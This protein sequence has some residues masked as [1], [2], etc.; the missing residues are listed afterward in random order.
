[1]DRSVPRVSARAYRRR[2]LSTP[3]HRS[4]RAVE[5]VPPR[6]P[7]RRCEE[8]PLQKGGAKE[9]LCSQIAM[10]NTPRTSHRTPAERSRFPSARPCCCFPRQLF[11]FF[12]F[13]SGLRAKNTLRFALL[14]VDHLRAGLR[15]QGGGPATQHGAVADLNRR[16]QPRLQPHH[17]RRHG[18]G[19]AR[20]EEAFGHETA[21]H[22]LRKPRRRR[23]EGRRPRS[24]RT[25][26]R[27]R[28]PRSR[29]HRRRRRRREMT[30]R[31]AARPPVLTGCCAVAEVKVAGDAVAEIEVGGRGRAAGEV[32]IDG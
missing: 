22:L 12:L 21:T 27:G 32:E 7:C 4:R 24:C 3:R 20:R 19:R 23:R 15:A 31:P 18:G 5:E 30:R 11:T 13:P 1:M 9:M 10:Y 29:R 8:D 28:Q 16:P 2:S 14:R 6:A 17:L 26:G 25:E